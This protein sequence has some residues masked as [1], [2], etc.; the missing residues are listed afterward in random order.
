M[1]DDYAPI[2][3][4]AVIGDCRSAALISRGGSVD[5]LSWP[6]Y[7]S[8]S[9]FGALLDMRRGGRF[10]VAPTGAYRATR[11][12][13]PNTNVLE[14][15]FETSGGSVA[16]RDCMPVRSEEKK[17]IRLIPGH[18]LLREVEGISGEVDLE[19]LYE[20]RPDYATSRVR[21]K[22]RGHLGLWCDTAHGAVALQSDIDLS[23]ESGRDRATGAARICAGER[24]YL[25]LIF[26]EELP[27]ILPT[28]GDSARDRIETTAA[29]W[30]GWAS[31]CQ[32]DGPHQSDVVRSALTLKLLVY[33]PSGAVVAAP[34][35]SLPECP[36]GVRNWDYR[37][38][39][40]RDAS[41]T[42]RSLFSLGYHDEAHAFLSWMLHAT[43]L[44]WPDLQVVYDVFGEER[45]PERCLPQFEG[46]ACSAPVR[47]GNDAHRQ[48]QLDVYGEVLD[49][50][51]QFID[52]GGRFDGDTRAFL[53][54]IGESIRQRWREPDD[55]LWEW[56]SG[57][58][59]HTHSKVMCWVV[60]D[61]L[62][63]LC[64]A[65]HLDHPVEDYRNVRDEIRS[66]VETRGFNDEFGSYTSLLDGDGIDASLLLLPLYGYVAADAPRMRSTIARIR[67]ELGHG[68]NVRRYPS[69]ADDGLPPGE[70]AFNLCG[71]WAVE[72]LALSGAIDEAAGALDR[73]CRGANDVGLLSEQVDWE[74]GAFL[75]NFPQAY[76]HVGLINAAVT[77]RKCR[78]RCGQRDS[79]EETS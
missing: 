34:T 14:T 19:V 27:A 12:Y 20:P 15:T 58:K 74:T 13:L 29:W 37:Y 33:A 38:C 32:Y 8:P 25:S 46:Y 75:G 2:S 39:W 43:R 76:S 51:S 73:L 42:L 40:L 79:C 28:L 60:M 77:L 48:L 6:R 49:A 53:T 56:R 23:V 31:R 59:Q 57:R 50:A 21:L 11:R 9:L 10:R 17:R 68:A 65:G 66:V 1:T 18:E 70:G 69:H 45:L 5:W 71:F 24:R 3:D 44:T 62:I 22:R 47:V 36:G 7:D 78:Q 63:Q 16:L 35:T 64:E 41:V 30:R 61:R 72:C 52:Q 55:G 26:E 67:D 4:Y 54:G